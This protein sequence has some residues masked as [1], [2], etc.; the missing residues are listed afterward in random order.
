MGQPTTATVKRQRSAKHTIFPT[1]S[2]AMVSNQD[3]AIRVYHGRQSSRVVG[4][5]AIRGSPAVYFHT[6][7]SESVRLSCV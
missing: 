1:F 7:R 2:I 6:P 3:L 4:R 5:H